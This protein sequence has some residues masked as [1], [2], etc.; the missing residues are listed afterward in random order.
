LT[1]KP[2]NPTKKKPKK[3]GDEGKKDELGSLPHKRSPARVVGG[4]GV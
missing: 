3:N 2:K 1:K 4:V